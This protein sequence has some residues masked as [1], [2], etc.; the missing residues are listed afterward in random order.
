MGSYITES[1]IE[2]IKEYAKHVLSNS[3]IM[4]IKVGSAVLTQ[5]E[6]NLDLRVITRLVDQI[7]RIHDLG[8]K[9][10]L[11]SSGAV[12]AGKRYLKCKKGEDLPLWKKQAAA[13]IGQSRLMHIYDEFFEKYNKVTAQVLLTRDDLKNRRRFLN[14][15]NTFN[16][17]LDEGVIPIVN[18]NDTVA[19]D[20]LKFGDNDSLATLLLNLVGADLFINLTSAQGVYTANP[21]IDKDAKPIFFI[22]DIKSLDIDKMCQGKTYVGSGGMY[23]KLI[24]A[25]RAAQIGV[26]TLIVSGKIP[27]VLEKVF[28][29]EILGT[30]IKPLEE[31]VS[32][33]KFWMAYNLEPKGIIYIDT[34]AKNAL[35]FKGKSLLPV[36]VVGVNGEFFEGDLVKIVSEDEVEIGVGLT[37]YSAKDLIKIKGKKTYELRE[38]LGK[39]KIAEEVI[40]RD[41]L[42]IDAIF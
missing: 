35:L 14:A 24:A 17:L 30:W 31:T 8:K 40:H 9:V 38:I 39:T 1:D 15:Q 5:K 13:A 28:S 22:E 12:A 11:V 41:N 18:E 16:T 23:S 10:I 26:P 19:V 6:G 29:G 42:L 25:K 34:G 21:D 37:N 33:K 3:K 36:G 7:A 4:I 2:K 32:R 27:F 20:E